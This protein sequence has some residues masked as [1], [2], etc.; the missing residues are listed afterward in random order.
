MNR[1]TLMMF[2]I[3]VCVA[4][5]IFL[6]R[7]TNK[8]KDEFRMFSDQVVQAMNSRMIESNTEQETETEVENIEEKKEE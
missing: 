3:V 7:E 8:T 1:E 6:F 2:G 5:I 4:G